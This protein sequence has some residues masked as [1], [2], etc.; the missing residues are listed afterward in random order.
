MQDTCRL[1]VQIELSS[2]KM[3]ESYEQAAHPTGWT[4]GK[5]AHE[6]MIHISSHQGKEN[7]DD[8]I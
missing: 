3:S 6:T 7:S 2:L 1:K 8:E 4:S 5:Q